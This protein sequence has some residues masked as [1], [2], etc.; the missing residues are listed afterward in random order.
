MRRKTDFKS[1]VSLGFE[2]LPTAVVFIA[3]LPARRMATLPVMS[4]SRLPVTL[5]ATLLVALLV[6]FTSVFANAYIPRSQTIFSRTARNGGKG[7][8]VIEQEVHF[9]S[10]AEPV[11]VREHWVIENGENM[12]L[13]AYS[14]KGAKENARV[15]A[16]YHDGK[17]TSADGGGT[18]QITP[19]SPEFI[20]NFEHYRSGRSLLEALVRSHVVPAA[21]MRERS[22]P[23]TANIASYHPQAEPYVRLGRENGTVS[24]IFGEPTPIEAPHLNAEA[25]IQQDG[26]VLEKIRF[27]SQS[28]ISADRFATSAGNLRLPRERTITWNNN[29]VSIRVI[30]V[31]SMPATSVGK[32]VS[33]GSITT[34]DAR[35]YHLP[36]IPAVKEFYARFR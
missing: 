15:D 12:R 9:R 25:W 36:E 29:I 14:P 11:T 34:A 31:K 20:E 2:A 6:T 22:R 33:P 26:F 30:S 3:T 16:L 23:T 27:P 8:Y 24:W 28:E 1:K 4:I 21:I 35:A 32:A 7:A 18:L 10:L 13:T 5:P 17:K 19:N